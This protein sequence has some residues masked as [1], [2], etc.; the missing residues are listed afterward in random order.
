MNPL[1][2]Q[3]VSDALWQWA[4]DNCTCGNIASSG[5]LWRGSAPRGW[6]ACQTC[7]DAHYF[8]VGFSVWLINELIEGGYLQCPSA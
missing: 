8:E 7:H 5:D 1:D 2:K 6:K 4:K 3:K